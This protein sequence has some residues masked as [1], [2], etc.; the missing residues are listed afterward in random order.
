MENFFDIVMFIILCLNR[1]LIDK[2]P[3]P[4]Q[5]ISVTPKQNQQKMEV[6][7]KN[8][9]SVEN[10]K[11]LK[12]IDTGVRL[13]AEN[14]AKDFF[15][16][17]FGD[18]KAYFDEY[19]RNSR[20]LSNTNNQ[21]SPSGSESSVL[22][23]RG[24]IRPRVLV[25]HS[26]QHSSDHSP[27][28]NNIKDDIF[29][30]FAPVTTFTYGVRNSKSTPD[31]INEHT[32]PV[33]KRGEDGYALFSQEKPKGLY[34]SNMVNLVEYSEKCKDQSFSEQ[35][36][37]LCKEVNSLEA[38]FDWWSVFGP[39]K[40]SGTYV[41]PFKT[42]FINNNQQEFPS[43]EEMDSTDAYTD[44]LRNSKSSPNSDDPSCPWCGQ[45][46]ALK[47]VK[48]NS[49]LS[50]AQTG[51]KQSDKIVDLPEE[52][53][54]D[55][56]KCNIS[57]Y[58]YSTHFGQ[59]GTLKGGLVYEKYLN[60]DTNDLW[61][62]QRIPGSADGFPHSRYMI[63][64]NGQKELPSTE[65]RLKPLKLAD[66][67]VQLH[68]TYTD[69]IKNSRPAIPK[70]P[71]NSQS[72]SGNDNEEICK[73]IPPDEC[74]RIFGPGSASPRSFGIDQAAYSSNDN[75][76]KPV[77]DSDAEENFWWLFNPPKAHA[78]EL[79]NSKQTV[80]KR[81]RVLPRVLPVE[82]QESETNQEEP[83]YCIGCGMYL[84]KEQNKESYSFE[85]NMVNFIEYSEKCKDQTFS[86]KY[87]SLCKEI[88]IL[89]SNFDLWEFF[90]PFKTAG[91]IIRH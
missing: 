82:R 79:H 57:H 81:P 22:K 74:E 35:Y 11:P 67:S 55:P 78:D 83:P 90:K 42:S 32:T 77:K 75:L 72:T 89:E 44:D 63:D 6:V 69:S 12:L 41:R 65:K 15:G 85:P 51:Y 16:Y 62:F 10:L 76:N 56:S 91:T 25:R 2:I 52:C 20:F 86:E 58:I 87:P 66:T 24:P 39:F 31:T 21:P 29:Q 47:P 70:R 43:T 64:V 3:A 14:N 54:K 40:T 13:P 5:K 34:K 19:H 71:L 48:I 18:S 38:N 36:P 27:T 59:G 80:P 8:L 1:P 49:R 45:V 9:N 50:K 37:S 4:L 61:D 68:E 60:S 33:P 23:P 30:F 53:K 7:N 46:K 84:Q 26:S 28:E 17:H 88:D 73:F